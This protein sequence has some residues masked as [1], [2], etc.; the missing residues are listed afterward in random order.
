[1][2]SILL[3]GKWMRKRLINTQFTFKMSKLVGG[4]GILLGSNPMT[5]NIVERARG[6]LLRYGM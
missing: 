4:L 2:Y 1:M 6:I 5:R 3:N